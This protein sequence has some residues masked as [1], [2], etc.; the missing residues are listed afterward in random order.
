MDA[1]TIASGN[2]KEIIGRG[3]TDAITSAFGGG[4]INKATTNI[5]KMGQVVADIVAGL[6]TMVGFL[7]KIGSWSARNSNRA[8]AER[9]GR[10]RT[11]YDPM[12]AINPGLTP[13]FMKNLKDRQKAD[14]AAAKRQKELA[15][16]AVKQTKAIKEQTALAKTKAVLDKSSM[17]MNMDLIQNTA[18]LMGK[19]TQDET[20]R[21]KLQQ[22]ILLEN[23]E[24][25]GNLAQQLLS[26]QIAAMKLSSTNPLGGFSDSLNAALQAA[27]QL[28][29]ELAM[30]GADKVPIPNI[31]APITPTSVMPT[32]IQKTPEN[33]LGIPSFYGYSGF[34]QSF[35]PSAYPTE[36]V[37]S[38]D[39]SAAAL[40]ITSTVITNSANGNNNNYNSQQSFAG[41]RGL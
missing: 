32:D 26:S 23:A 5:E 8:I 34:G 6:G 12:S 40:G 15:A 36:I 20:L 25:A 18:A 24:Q 41:G 4:D 33:P 1:L 22:A 9:E 14:A 21:L 27:R 7:G 31:T 16:L 37:V 30:M 17:V 39:P 29:N 35:K 19:V 13:A 2:A 28:R 3:L 11:P 38:I 10:N